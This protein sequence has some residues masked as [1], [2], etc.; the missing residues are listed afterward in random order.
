MDLYGAL[1]VVATACSLVALAVALAVL[2]ASLPRTV[3]RTVKD[4]AERAERAERTC[5]EAMRGDAARNVAVEELAERVEGLLERVETRRRRIAASES[6]QRA[7]VPEEPPF[8]PTDRE[9]V[10]ARARA[11]GRIA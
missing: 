2:R 9:Q 6:R 8:D 1:S 4:A 10:R 7:Q 5:A 3:V 11:T